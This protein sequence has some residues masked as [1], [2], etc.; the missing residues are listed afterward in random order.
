MHMTI[1]TN[2][3]HQAL[4]PLFKVLKILLLL[5]FIPIKRALQAV[6]KLKLNYNNYTF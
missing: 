1:G 4:N 6:I 3:E 5:H 2:T